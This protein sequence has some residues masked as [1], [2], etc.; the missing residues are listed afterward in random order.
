M[1][2]HITP[3]KTSIWRFMIDHKLQNKGIGRYALKVA[4]E[5]VKKRKNLREI[6]IC[7]SPK[8]AIAKKLYFSIGF[9]ETDITD[10]G[11]EAYASINLPF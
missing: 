4:I 9:K 11:N 10:D 5:E 8:N 6:E 7:Y 2:V 1:W 3:E